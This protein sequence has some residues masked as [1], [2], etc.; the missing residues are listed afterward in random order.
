MG[1]N[2]DARRRRPVRRLKHRLSLDAYRGEAAATFTVCAEGRLETFTNEHVVANIL[3][4]LRRACGQH[5]CRILI[6]C[7]M[8]DHVH[9]AL[10]GISPSSDIWKAMK[11]FKQLS[12]YWLSRNLP[13]VK[14]QGDF[15]DHILR[16]EHELARHLRY[17]AWNPV[18]RGLVSEWSEHPFTGSDLPDLPAIL[19]DGKDPA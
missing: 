3:L 8:P 13:T 2:R 16:D 9:V 15:F 18:R 17:I 12:G 5:R 1:D 10:Q 7:F 4:A 19:G 14:W 11:L 6:Y